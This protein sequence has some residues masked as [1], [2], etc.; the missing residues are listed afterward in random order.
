MNKIPDEEVT[1]MFRANAVKNV[2]PVALLAFEKIREVMEAHGKLKTVLGIIA[3]IVHTKGA[4]REAI[5]EEP[6]AADFK[7]Q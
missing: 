4:N 3:R 5:E 2:Q 6:D 1:K 7:I